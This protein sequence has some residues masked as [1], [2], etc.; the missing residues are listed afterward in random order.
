MGA[1]VDT[2]NNPGLTVTPL[3]PAL[4]HLLQACVALRTTNAKVLAN[5][6]NRSPHTIRTEFQRILSILNV[7]S[8]Y[9]ALRAGE[10]EGWLHADEAGQHRSRAIPAGLLRTLE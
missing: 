7:H 6:L 4:Q 5:H 3:T 9:S 10:H 1:S 8:R 2:L